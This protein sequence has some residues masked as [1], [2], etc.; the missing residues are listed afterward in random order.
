[1]QSSGAC[2]WPWSM[3]WVLR[4]EGASRHSGAREFHLHRPVMRR[5]V[6]Q[7]AVLG[8]KFQ[9][10]VHPKDFPIKT[11]QSFCPLRR[12]T[13]YVHSPQK[14]TFGGLDLHLQDRL[15]LDLRKAFLKKVRAWTRN[16]RGSR[17]SF[18]VWCSAFL[19]IREMD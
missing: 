4:K 15:H 13:C 19:G 8:P 3:C 10:H 9:K 17:R 12:E 6:A 7:E 16:R 14:S 18:H 5:E 11:R 2:G 1:M